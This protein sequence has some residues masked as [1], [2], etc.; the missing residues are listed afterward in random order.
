MVIVSIRQATFQQVIDELL[1]NEKE[2]TTVGEIADRVSELCNDSY[3]LPYTKKK[4]VE[5]F[6]DTLHISQIDNR[7]NVVTIKRHVGEIIHKFRIDHQEQDGEAEQKSKIIKAAAAL[8]RSEI[9]AM[10]TNRDIYPNI[11]ELGDRDKHRGFVPDTLLL[12]LSEIFRGKKTENDLKIT[13]IGHCIMQLAR[14]RTIIS[15][16]LFGLTMDLHWEF[17]SRNLI[18]KLYEKGFC[19]S[20]DEA[21]L[22]KACAAKHQVDT[23]PN[24]EGRFCHFIA[25]NVDHN[26]ITLDGR[27][28]Y[29]GM[30]L[31][32]T[33]T[34]AVKISHTISRDITSLEDRP[35]SLTIRE[36][37]R[38]RKFNE[39]LIYEYLPEIIVDDARRHLD[40]LWKIS[41]PC[42]VRSVWPGFMQAIT[43]GDHQGKASFH[44]LPMV[45]IDPTNMSCVYSTL[46]FVNDQ[47]IKY[48]I[49]P[50]VTFDQPLWMKAKLILSQEESLKDLILILGGFHTLMSFLGSICHI[51]KSSGLSA[52]LQ[53]VFAE[54]TVTHI[55][56]GKAYSRAVRGHFLVDGALNALLLQKV[57]TNEASQ[58]IVE[59]ALRLF[60]DVSVG[61]STSGQDDTIEALDKLFQQIKMDVS[62]TPTGKLWVQYM[63]TV[64]ILRSTLKAQRTGDFMLYLKS[65]KDMLPYFAASGHN[66]YT[67]SVHLFLQDMLNLEEKN[68]TVYQ[69][70]SSGN[71]FVRRSDRFWG[72]LPTDLVIEQV[73]MRALKSKSGLTHGRGM[74]ETQRTRWLLTMPDY[75]RISTEMDKLGSC[76]PLRGNDIR[77]SAMIRDH[78][79]TTTVFKYLECHDP[80]G[81]NEY[82]YDIST[83]IASADSNVHIAKDI[84][85]SIIASMAGEKMIDYIFKKKN[86]VKLMGPKIICDR[87]VL[88]V[89]PQLLFQRLLILVSNSHIDLNYVFEY[90]LSV[91]PTA[92]F[93]GYGMLNSATKQRLTDGIAKLSNDSQETSIPNAECNVLDGGSLLQR[94]PWTKGETYKQIVGTYV[95]M[96]SNYVHPI[97]VFDGYKKC[98]STKAVTHQKRARG[99]RSTPVRISMDLPLM[100]D[101]ESF[102]SNNLNKQNFIDM[103]S[104]EMRKNNIKTIHAEDDADLLIVQTSISLA[105][106]KRTFVIAE[107][108]DILVLLCHY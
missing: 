23:F 67:K 45:D 68:P 64:D 106:E 70:F 95:K 22:F 83:G 35:R 38:L 36:F 31:M 28:T 76:A 102:L 59:C 60:D 82:V 89:D 2:Q 18:E 103:L 3:S 85:E 43:K 75:A 57:Q 34:P 62:L 54:N 20:Y 100:V 21:I 61:L 80:F 17:G 16:L 87:D 108:T 90:E 72:A 46:V 19:L 73:L 11:S 8:I 50:I 66:S 51:M 93:R 77:P 47:C 53:L 13:S 49:Q 6:G 97:I 7:P 65:L 41:Y 48:G 88:A 91:Y 37:R 9:D 40:L 107:D 44:F 96:V 74:D 26:T 86:Q 56:S 10:Q 98:K 94:L 4:L 15:P 29:H 27:G 25:D 71:L 32:Y 12:F 39:T 58:Q 81:E 33:A 42:K 52:V 84:G 1:E 14:P 101:K 5:Y 92:L 30:G 63:E 24:L 78:T 99:K 55:L 104:D 79:D 105:M 69:E